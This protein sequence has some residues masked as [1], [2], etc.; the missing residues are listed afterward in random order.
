MK[1]AA[2]MKRKKPLRNKK[3]MRRRSAK[4]E[5][6]YAGDAATE[7]RREFRARILR[8][9]PRCE[10]GPRIA[11][12]RGVVNTRRIIIN[13]LFSSEIVFDGDVYDRCAISSRDVHEILA[14]SAGG[15][16]LDES[17]VLAVCRRCHRWIGDH[18]REATALG[19]RKSRYA[20]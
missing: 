16:I 17:N 5:R 2:P 14:R 1:R 15:S 19:L 11:A 8:E 18:P 7:G 9:R 12:L 13:K 3:P 4:M 20:R 10:A 6:K